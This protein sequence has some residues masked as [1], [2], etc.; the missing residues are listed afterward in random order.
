MK[1]IPLTKGQVAL[2]D[3][4]NYANLAK[5]KWHCSGGYAQRSYGPAAAR[6]SIRM[7]NE[8]LPA[9]VGFFVD[10]INR[11]RLDNRRSNLRH[12]TN[13]QNCWNSAARATSKTG[14]K[15]VS[16][17]EEKQRFRAV[18][19]HAGRQ[20]FLG[21]FDKIEEAAAARAAKEAQLRGAYAPSQA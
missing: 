15:G 13:Q 1:T 18:I 9:R 16:W 5:Y 20:V 14:V 4:E 2:V 6:K 7:H 8:I 17:R 3:D 10:H 21:H 12:V 11:D 19:E